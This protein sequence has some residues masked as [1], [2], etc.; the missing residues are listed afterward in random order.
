MTQDQTMKLVDAYVQACVDLECENSI[1]GAVD[2]SS[3]RHTDDARNAVVAAIDA[4]TKDAG[5]YQWLRHG[6]NDDQI[7][8]RGTYATYLPR[9]EQLDQAIDAAIAASKEQV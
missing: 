7:I 5:R 3:V 2:S 4:L 1:Y 6:D 8:Y 9:N